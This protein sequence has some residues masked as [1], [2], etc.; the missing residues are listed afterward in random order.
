MSLIIFWS[1]S[2][3][4]YSTILPF[5]MWKTPIGLARDPLVM[6]EPIVYFIE[7]DRVVVGGGAHRGTR[8]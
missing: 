8:R 6:A 1:R 3:S 5:S 4:Q 7:G 2:S